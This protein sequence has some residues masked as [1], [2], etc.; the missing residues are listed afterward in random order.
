MAVTYSEN[1]III[2]EAPP[3]VYTGKVSIATPNDMTSSDTSSISYFDD[4]FYYLNGLASNRLSSFYTTKTFTVSG[5]H[6]Y[7]IQASGVFVQR[8]ENFSTFISE[9]KLGPGRPSNYPYFIRVRWSGNNMSIGFVNSAGTDIV[10]GNTFTVPHDGTLHRYRYLV[11]FDNTNVKC[12][13]DDTLKHTQTFT[14]SP[15]LNQFMAAFGARSNSSSDYGGGEFYNG[16]KFD[17]TDTYI[18]INGELAWGC[19]RNPD[20]R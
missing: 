19:E 13:I 6:T 11:D 15:K 1:G 2:R 10:Y 12:Y 5:I 4:R 14:I 8:N 3:V 7:E 16:T 20:Y 18:K 9:A 17:Y